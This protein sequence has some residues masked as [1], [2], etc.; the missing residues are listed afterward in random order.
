MMRL[1]IDED[2]NE[3]VRSDVSFEK[4]EIDNLRHSEPVL[5]LDRMNEIEQQM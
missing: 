2:K 4:L 3:E 5:K 1:D